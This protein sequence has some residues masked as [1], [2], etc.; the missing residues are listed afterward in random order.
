M[1]KNNDFDK[2]KTKQKIYK[3]KLKLTQLLVAELEVNVKE[4]EFE[5]NELKKE[6]QN[7]KSKLFIN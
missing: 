6:L 2:I 1:T 3:K 7:V 4:K 5:I